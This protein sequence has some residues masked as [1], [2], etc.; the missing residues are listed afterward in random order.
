MAL[1][2]QLGAGRQASHWAQRNELIATDFACL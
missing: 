1:I 2:E